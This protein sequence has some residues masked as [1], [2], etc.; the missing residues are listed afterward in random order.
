[1]TNYTKYGIYALLGI[2]AL[3]LLLAIL[4]KYTSLEIP[5][6]STFTSVKDETTDQINTI[7]DP[8]DQ[9]SANNEITQPESEAATAAAAAALVSPSILSPDPQPINDGIINSNGANE[10]AREELAAEEAIQAEES[11][12]PIAPESFKCEIII[13]NTCRLKGAPVNKLFDDTKF[14]GPP[15]TNDKACNE[16]KNSWIGS[17]GHSAIKYKFK[18]PDVQDT[19]P[20]KQIGSAGCHPENLAILACNGDSKCEIIGRQ[21]NGC[22]HKLSIGVEGDQKVP[23]DYTNLRVKT[24]YGTYIQM[25]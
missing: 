22:W 23:N 8:A 4:A 25:K 11:I 12:K 3:L 19:V 18:R 6:L 2:L 21:S 10:A 7:I 9:V 20:M 13:S 5:Y 24:S 16:R 15:A 14:G 1:M 17:C